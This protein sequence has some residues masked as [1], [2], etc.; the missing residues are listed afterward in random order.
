MQWFDPVD[1]KGIDV[2]RIVGVGHGPALCGSKP[3][4]L[5]AERYLV[6]EV[7]RR[8][9]RF[10]DSS[11]SGGGDGSLR[12]GGLN[13]GLAGGRIDGNR[14]E[15]YI[16]ICQRLAQ[17]GRVAGGRRRAL[18]LSADI[19]EEA[20]GRGIAAG[21]GVVVE[22]VFVGPAIIVDNG[23][24]KMEAVAK[25]CAADAAGY[26]VDR[27]DA[28][29]A[30]MSEA[31]APDIVLQFFDERVVG[32]LGFIGDRAGIGVLDSR[33]GFLEHAL[34]AG[35]GPGAHSEVDGIYK[36]ERIKA[37]NGGIDPTIDRDKGGIEDGGLAHS[38]GLV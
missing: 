27:L 13:V 33:A 23:G 4:V 26:R 38:G 36:A 8:S 15:L 24:T 10:E 32:L 6:V 35:P 3:L 7:V 11:L 20:A 16:D 21:A 14:Q 31:R 2:L 37:E 19:N 18:E 30:L 5:F 17:R 28:R 9:V 25:G 29:A 22:A 1:A 34:D 12:D